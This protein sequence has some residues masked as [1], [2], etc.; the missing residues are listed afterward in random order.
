[1]TDP[2]PNSR[3]SSI[4]LI[5]LED[6]DR[7]AT[8]L[9]ELLQRSAGNS[10][11]VEAL[12]W[13]S[14]TDR[15]EEITQANA[16]LFHAS[17]LEAEQLRSRVESIRGVSRAAIIALAEAHDEELLLQVLEAGVAGLVVP[18][19]LSAE[20]L[21]NAVVTAIHVQRTLRNFELEVECAVH[22]TNH[23]RITN[24]ENRHSLELRLSP[25]L[26]TAAR[27][28]RKLS[29]LFVETSGLKSVN[30]GLGHN[31]GNQLLR[32]VA[33]RLAGSVRESDDVTR[34][35]GDGA[36]A[37][38][39]HL[40]GSEFT[41]LLSE[42][43]NSQD[44][45]LVAQRIIESLSD[46][47]ILDGQEV[48]VSTSIGIAVFPLDGGDA[49]S[50]LR[51]AGSAKMQAKSVGGSA[52]RF[53]AK[54]MNSEA[55]RRLQL[56]SLLHRA[57]ERGEFSLHY[58]PLRDAQSSKLLA[59]EALLRWSTE[60]LGDISPAEFIPIAEDSNLIIP[61]GEW[62]LQSASEQYRRWL[63]AGY[64]PIRLAVNLSG[65]QLERGEL[66]RTVARILSET[67]MSSSHL[68]LEIT[69]TTIMRHDGHA[70]QAL[71]ELHDM[72]VGLALDDFG[73]GFSTLTHLSSI[74][75]D[76]LKI[77]RSFISQIESRSQGADIASAL[78]AMAHSLHLA[79]V[80]EGV[81]TV[82]QVNFLRR[83]GCD[84]LQGFLLGRPMPASDFVQ[85]LE[86]AKRE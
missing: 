28:D 51:N 85:H 68:E 37:A 75:V 54:R 76:R 49:D 70:R 8:R 59:A 35:R 45:A 69:E 48:F 84:E 30:D 65:R 55:A 9:G 52:F 24:L 14:L 36:E 79:V 62:V 2:E 6:T 77:D 63:D 25:L 40:G 71:Q 12:P 80:A 29:V 46:P 72:G 83:R 74:P 53:Y 21:I 5:V 22:M 81:E 10:F 42:I 47:F 4:R 11:D 19:E 56:G 20:R 58:Q 1:M 86:R 33:D 44:A 7:H 66:A 78:I 67:G 34:S 43:A 26:A 38:I 3:A 15:Q 50:L 27:N 13:R 57:L 64:Q 82:E 31:A 41:V 73:T 16:V 18:S 61:I 23:D 17:P 60:E 39:S 32:D